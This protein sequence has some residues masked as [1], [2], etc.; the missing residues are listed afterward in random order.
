MLTILMGRAR[1]GKS[2]RILREITEKGD[3]SRQILLV[4]E[5]ASH[6][7][8]V[9]L[10]RACGDTASR[11][12]EVLSFRRLATRVLAIT[13]GA[14]D[15]TLDAGGKLLT[16]QMSLTELAP[17]L[18]VYRRPSQRAAFL[19][20]LMGLL[21]EL[22][23]Y[24]VT[25]ETFAAQ[26]Q[27][28]SG[29][30]GDKL[31]DLALIY[32]DYQ[33]RLCRPGLDGRDRMSKL[34]DHLEES[35]YADGKDVYLDGFSY[36]NGLEQGVLSVFLRRA[37]S[38]MV[39]LL[40][41][42]NNAGEIF[43]VSVRTQDRLCRL[44]A[45]AGQVCEIQYVQDRDDSP[46]G[47]VERAFFGGDETWDGPTDAVRVREA[48][49]AFTE[50]EQ[51]AADIVRLV[52]TG[53]C[54]FR[55]I[56]VAA[57]NMKDYE[58]TIENVF[59]RYGVPVFLSRRSDILEKPVLSLLA[60]ALDSVTGGC[61]YEDMFHYL[62]TGLA[63]LSPTECDRL[64]NY[65]LTWEIHGSLWLREADWAANPGGYGAPWTEAQKAELQELNDLRH[66]VRGPLKLLSDGMF[67]ATVLVPIIVRGY[68][69]PL[70]IQTTLL[71]AGLGTLLFHACTKFK[72]PAF[73]GSSFAYLGGFAAVAD[74]NSGKYADM[75]GA[76]KLPYALGG[77]VVA[78]LLYLVLALLFK[79]IGPY[80]VMRYFPPVVTGP[81]IIL[82]GLILAPSAVTN[83]SACWPLALLAMAVIIVFNIWGKGMLKII[84]IL[85]GV[86][87]PYAVALLTRQVDFTAVG[88]AGFFGLQ[89]FVLAKFDL[90]A[91]LVMF[92]H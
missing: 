24:A 39:T 76:E 70:S 13:G 53:K 67:G 11:H 9:D 27:D 68:G 29:A 21:D 1:S 50:V 75:T 82:I 25:P 23:S 30:M 61:E 8:E 56:T 14:A 73:L 55:D 87:I 5:H 54:R 17:V 38:V 86:A 31:R 92:I 89:P 62:K 43:E 22:T 66:R 46:L 58:S 28:I 78:G 15:V 85:L 12:A 26:A 4:P 71:F 59:E 49:T 10:C 79:V 74:L 57:R 83:A 65:A 72:V 33:A 32:A 51:T 81:I 44:A 2:K 48:D 41:E 35:G 3:S 88:E 42:E 80:K 84:P 52:K 16:L 20:Q 45:E 19:E 60:G 77:V 36:F 37:A 47:L 18:K 69:L 34:Q 63:G 91:I 64:E 6:Q 90:S 7:A 40:G